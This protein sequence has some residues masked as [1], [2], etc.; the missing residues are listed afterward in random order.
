MCT[1]IGAQSTRGFGRAPAR[2]GRRRARVPHEECAEAARG[3]GARARSLPRAATRQ[4]AAASGQS[5]NGAVAR[6]SPPI[7]GPGHAAEPPRHRVQREVATAQAFGSELAD[8]RLVRGPVQALPDPEH[9]RE[10]G[11]RHERGRRFEP[12]AGRVHTEP[13]DG[14]ED[15][16]QRE[17][18]QAALPFE[19]AGDREL[20]EHDRDRVEEE[21]GADLSL[22]QA[23]V[24]AD[25]RREEVE[26]RVARGDE[27]EV[28]RPQAEEQPVAQHLA[29]RAGGLA[30]AER[31]RAGVA[32]ER[33]HAD[34]G[35][36]REPVED[37]QDG[38][39]RRRVGVRDQAAGQPAEADA[40]VHRDALLRERGVKS[41]GRRQP[42][43]QR[44]LARPERRAADAFEREQRVRMPRLA[45]EREQPEPE[46][47]DDEAAAEHA[48]RSEAVDHGAHRD[49]G[50]QLR[51]RRD[52]DRDPGG[53]DPEPADVG[54]VDRE[55]REHDAVP[56]RVRD[57]ADLEQPDV[58]GELRIE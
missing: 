44:R 50:D 31:R 22:A 36:E 9:D 27:E 6:I 3:R 35:E 5:A 24:V 37:E 11:D 55:E 17:R 51:C 26:Q 53:R 33:E 28:Q 4:T 49:A 48:F 56:E 13:R 43:D 15:R 32:D 54:Q 58:A 10:D 45:H 23:A 1:V 47:L 21:D 2:R 20:R 52:R 7:A 39:R 42:G 16:H 41:R 46:G 34:V 25:E 19:P 30:L 40:E 29:V 12:V 8:E 38:E 57:A 18:A 14:P